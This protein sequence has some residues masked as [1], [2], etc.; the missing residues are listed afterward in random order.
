[1]PFPD[2]VEYGKQAAVSILLLAGAD[3]H[4]AKEDPATIATFEARNALGWIQEHG[5][6]SGI[7]SAVA[8]GELE[9]LELFH[10]SRVDLQHYALGMPM[11]NLAVICGQLDVTHFLIKQGADVRSRGD[12]GQT[13][14]DLALG[15]VEGDADEIRT[16]LAAEVGR[17]Q[18][19]DDEARQHIP[20]SPSQA[21]SETHNKISSQSA[22]VI[23]GQVIVL[24]PFWPQ[25]PEQLELRTG[26]R[27]DLTEELANDWCLQ[28]AWA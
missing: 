8:F 26:D 28:W 4:A 22:R 3:P 10:K 12:Q 7:A 20:Q 13:P 21:W 16:L 27:I 24:H 25:S 2:A 9:I 6:I 19:L 14:Y 23:L 11:L 18:W 5:N 15:L 1:M 17:R